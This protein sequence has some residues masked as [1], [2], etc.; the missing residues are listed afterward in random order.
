MIALSI[1]YSKDSLF[2]RK[3]NPPKKITDTAKRYPLFGGVS[4][5]EP[6]ISLTPVLHKEKQPRL[7]AELF[8]WWGMVDSNHRRQCQQIYSLSPLA[9][10][11]IPH[12][13]FLEL[14]DGLEPPTC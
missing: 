10:R 6:G 12:I 13:K 3:A 1:R 5:I 4:W 8:F 11:E 9:T 14:V 7:T 2:C